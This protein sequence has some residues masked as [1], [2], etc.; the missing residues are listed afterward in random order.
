[1][2]FVAIVTRMAQRV[3]RMGGSGELESEL[4]TRAKVCIMI[5]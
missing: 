1:M 3:T 5:L 4:R 2:G